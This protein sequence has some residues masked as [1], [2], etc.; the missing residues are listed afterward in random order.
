MELR[1]EYL[2]DLDSEED[3]CEAKDDCVCYSGNGDAG[4]AAEQCGS[5]ELDK[6]YGRLV[7]AIE[8]EIF[9]FESRTSALDT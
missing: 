9:L 8:C 6:L 2:G 3:R 1:Y 7:N 5:D 4:A